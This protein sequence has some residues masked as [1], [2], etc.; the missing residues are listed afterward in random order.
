MLETE[1]EC[2]NSPSGLAVVALLQFLELRA[3]AEISLNEKSTAVNLYYGKR[4]G[5]RN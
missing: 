2:P 4:N 3:K 1:A 5:L